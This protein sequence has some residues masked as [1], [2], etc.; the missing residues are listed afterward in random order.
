MGCQ[1]KEFRLDD[2]KIPFPGGFPGV[3]SV[4]PYIIDYFL[5]HR[6]ARAWRFNPSNGYG[7][8]RPYTQRPVNH[9]VRAVS[10][11]WLVI[12]GLTAAVAVA[13]LYKNANLWE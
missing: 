12:G 11:Q 7:Q 2:E 9:G 4:V 3:P 10:Y 8:R 13:S 6:Y 1:D 5:A